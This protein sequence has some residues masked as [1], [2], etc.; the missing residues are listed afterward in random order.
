MVKRTHFPDLE[1]MKRAMKMEILMIPEEV[2]C[3][4]IEREGK[5]NEKVC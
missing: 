2:F 5:M 4:C 1:A 3:G